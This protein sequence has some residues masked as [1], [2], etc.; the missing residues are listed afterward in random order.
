MGNITPIV[1]NLIIINV[2]CW[3]ATIVLP[4]VDVDLINLFGLHYWKA[5][6]FNLFQ[7]VSYMFLHSVNSISHLFFNMF[8]LFMFGQSL[9]HV[10]GQKRFL[11]YYMVTGIGAGLIQE[12]TWT[13]ELQ[14][15]T[16]EISAIAASGIPGGVRVSDMEVIY[17]IDELFKWQNEVLFNRYITVG[18]SGAVYGLLLAFG[19]IFPNQPM[20][21]LFI[22]F[23]I[24]A[25]YI[26]IGYGILELLM[27]FGNFSFD[28]VAHFAHL[29]GM[30]F[31][32]LLLLYWRKKGFRQ[33]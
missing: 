29:G 17:S 28:N 14:S 12:L 2:L 8:A 33:F 19:M 27:G 31:G 5:S 1:K 7:M 25:K 23:P 26:V 9:E 3:L 6:D 22:P 4:K 30:I 24:K 15:V 11:I 13:L 16:E 32:F 20:Y 18:A 21:I 10:L